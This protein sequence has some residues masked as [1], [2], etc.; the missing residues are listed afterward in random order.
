MSRVID[1]AAI[2]SCWQPSNGKCWS[3]PRCGHPYAIRC[4]TGDTNRRLIVALGS[5]LFIELWSRSLLQWPSDDEA[6]VSQL[7]NSTSTSD[8]KKSAIVLWA[9]HCSGCQWRRRRPEVPKR[10]W[11]KRGNGQRLNGRDSG[12]IRKFLAFVAR[13]V[14]SWVGARWPTV[15]RAMAEEMW[16]QTL[17]L[18]PPEKWMSP[19]QSTI[20][21]CWTGL[22]R[23]FK[24]SYVVAR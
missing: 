9:H 4:A 21:C 17:P 15:P 24:A 8:W 19:G 3:P 6:F 22:T 10:K 13:S 7:F 16:R 5:A 20:L 23:G 1:D 14:C 11:S 18:R 12:R 2:V